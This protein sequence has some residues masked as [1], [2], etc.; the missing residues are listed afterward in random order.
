[1]KSVEFGRDYLVRDM[2]FWAGLTFTCL[3]IALPFLRHF[4]YLLPILVLFTVLGDQKIRF[5]DEAKPFLAVVIAGICLSPIATDEGMKDIY[6]TLTGVSIAFLIDIPRIRLW[7]LFLTLL[8]CWLIYF[9]L[10]GDLRSSISFDI[11]KSSSP[12]E[13]S[14]SFLFGLLAPFALLEK[15]YRLFIL[16]SLMTV[17]SL[18]RIAVLAV[19]V[20]STFI[21]LGEKRAR[22]ILN[23]V[24]MIAINCLLLLLVLLY[25]YGTFDYF[26]TQWTGQSANE[27]GQGRKAL[28]SLPAIEIFSHPEQFFLFGQGPGSTYILAN[29]AIGSY[30]TAQRLHSDVLKIFYEY[31]LVFFSIFIGLMYSAK[32]FSTR[33]AFVFMNVIFLSDNTLIYAFMIFLFIYCARHMDYE[34]PQ[35]TRFSPY[36]YPRQEA[37]P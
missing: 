19:I 34:Q 8:T 21:L 26:I 5:G 22:L 18:K 27:F 15:R 1:M 17:L 31:G 9:G 10:F 29:K 36:Q 28:L 23:P 3:S 7:S 16:C 37:T 14:F 30:T 11:S 33:I 24:V 12:F 4:I 25:G 13:G 6:F 35:V 20:A 2:V 32:K